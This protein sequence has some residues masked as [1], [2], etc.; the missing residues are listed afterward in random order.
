PFGIPFYVYRM[1]PYYAEGDRKVAL[2]LGETSTVSPPAVPFPLFTFSEDDISGEYHHYDD[3]FPGL[4]T[5]DKPYW[6][7]Q[8]K[9]RL[10]PFNDGSS[11]HKTWNGF[12]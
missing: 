12:T 2:L 4:Q 6:Q 3:Y 5:P 7:V 1:V 8:G 10:P 11:E 9:L